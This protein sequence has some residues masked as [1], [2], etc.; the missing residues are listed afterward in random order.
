MRQEAEKT[1]K[2]SADR[3][4]TSADNGKFSHCSPTNRPT[5]AKATALQRDPAHRGE[6]H[7]KES[8]SAPEFEPGRVFPGAGTKQGGGREGSRTR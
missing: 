8:D 7:H 3:R 5:A 1:G 2:T 4:L 6:K